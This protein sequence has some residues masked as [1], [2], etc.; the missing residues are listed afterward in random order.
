M[1][2]SGPTGLG[3]WNGGLKRI[4]LYES[5]IELV[6]K[7]FQ[8]STLIKISLKPMFIAIIVEVLLKF[9]M[10]RIGRRLLTGT[11][12]SINL[13][14]HPTILNTKQLGVHWCADYV[15]SLFTIFTLIGTAVIDLA[16]HSTLALFLP[17]R[18][19]I[20]HHSP[21][22]TRSSFITMLFWY[23]KH[24]LLCLDSTT[25]KCYWKRKDGPENPISEVKRG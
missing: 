2:P 20:S 4:N 7:S 3:E 8:P 21:Y 17:W 12:I 14:S 23:R 6:Y 1:G 11:P 19:S 15:S 25:C 9:I 18:A 13:S 22:I 5:C 16:K 10:V 24:V